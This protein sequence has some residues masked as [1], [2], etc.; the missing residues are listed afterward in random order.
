M[1]DPDLLEAVVQDPASAP[2]APDI[3]M[4][5]DQPWA[6]AMMHYGIDSLRATL[7]E[8]DRY[9][10]FEV[11]ISIVICPHDGPGVQLISRMT[12][13]ADLRRQPLQDL[14]RDGHYILLG[15]TAQTRSRR[16]Q[17]HFVEASAPVAPLSAHDR[18]SLARRVARYREIFA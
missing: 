17:M 12:E 18:L 9:P 16:G 7:L 4:A 2:P 8:R 5:N 3:R 11:M 14:L 10:P 6:K 15:K 13:Q 1:I